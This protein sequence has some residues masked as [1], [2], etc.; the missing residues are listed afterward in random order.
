[1]Q[2]HTGCMLY[3]DV[4]ATSVGPVIRRL[5]LKLSPGPDS[6]DFWLDIPEISNRLEH[7]QI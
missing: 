2:V 1:M 4:H 6:A 3:V 5:A 7:N